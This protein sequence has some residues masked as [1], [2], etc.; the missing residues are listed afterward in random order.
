M[1]TVCM[2]SN[3]CYDLQLVG[4]VFFGRKQYQFDICWVC[5]KQTCS[6]SSGKQDSEARAS[7]YLCYMFYLYQKNTSRDLDNILGYIVI[8]TIFRWQ[9]NCCVMQIG[10]QRGDTEAGQWANSGWKLRKNSSR[11]KST[12]W[13]VWLIPK[14]FCQKFLSETPGFP[15]TLALIFFFFM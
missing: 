12:L 8:V 11:P 13:H 2:F 4:I 1:N 15:Q 9:H 10:W 7:L 14:H 5:I 3:I 6:P